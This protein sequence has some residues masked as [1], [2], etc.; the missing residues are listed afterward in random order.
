[1]ATKNV[2]CYFSKMSVC[3]AMT[4]VRLPPFLFLNF[5]KMH[6]KGYYLML[7]GLR[8]DNC[9]E[10]PLYKNSDISVTTGGK[11]ARFFSI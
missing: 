9:D 11:K 8:I 1:M 5:R 2:V 3:P 4:R 6:G 10:R 7:M